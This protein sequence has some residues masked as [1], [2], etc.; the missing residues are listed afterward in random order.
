M[1]TMERKP[2]T[3]CLLCRM[4]T[5]VTDN[6]EENASHQVLGKRDTGCWGAFLLPPR[7]LRPRLWLREH[8]QLFT[9]RL[10]LL[11]SLIAGNAEF[12]ERAFKNSLPFPRLRQ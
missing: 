5:F 2:L 8:K 7:L 9:H 12:V 1:E 10:M 11:Q 6:R 4:T 3:G